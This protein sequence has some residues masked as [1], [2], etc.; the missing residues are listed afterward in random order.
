MQYNSRLCMERIES[1][2]QGGHCVYLEPAAGRPKVFSPS[3]KQLIFQKRGLGEGRTF[4]G[5]GEK[6][7]YIETSRHQLPG[8]NIRFSDVAARRLLELHPRETV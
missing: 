1:N 3:N 6:N 7:M 2:H 8:D 5:G 4:L